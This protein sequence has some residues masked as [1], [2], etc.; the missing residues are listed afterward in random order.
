MQEVRVEGAWS[1][2]EGKE[3][4]MVQD[5]SM[6]RPAQVE[7]VINKIESRSKQTRRRVM[8]H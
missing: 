6:L 3:C 2:E 5:Q 7:K 8:G 1:C 4:K